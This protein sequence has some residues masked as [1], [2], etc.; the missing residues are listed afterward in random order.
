M[1][2]SGHIGSSASASN[3]H[4][5]LK[6][7]TDSIHKTKLSDKVYHID[8]SIINFP[9]LFSNISLSLTFAYISLLIQYVG[10]A[11]DLLGKKRLMA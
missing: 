2:V 10:A 11:Y 8:S 3:Y 5:L 1:K 6:L 4:I 9:Y 7:D